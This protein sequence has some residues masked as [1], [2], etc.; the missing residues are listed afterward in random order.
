MQSQLFRKKS[1][2]RI[3]SPEQL[4]DY[5]RVTNPGVWMVLAAVIALLAG[6][7][8]A[9]AVGT[10]ETTLN[11][12]GTLTEDGDEIVMVL[13]ADKK[14]LVKEDMVVR[15]GGETGHI[16]YVYEKD[17][18]VTAAATLENLSEPLPVGAYDVE[19]VTERVKPISFLL[20]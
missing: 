8:I 7:L 5:M 9:S 10:V 2:D 15:A 19:I 12:R 13:P 3:A 6:L 4:Q 14:D 17:G 20:N 11:V 1:I 18:I 16:D